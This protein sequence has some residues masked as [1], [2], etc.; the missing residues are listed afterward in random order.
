MAQAILIAVLELLAGLG[1][2]LT[3]MKLLTNNVESLAGDKIKGMFAKI[4]KS[5]FVG[6]GI[7]TATTAIVQSS[8]A[9]TVMVIGFV[10]AGIMSLTQATTIIYGA[11]IGTTITAQLVALGMLGTGSISMNAIFGAF[12]G[13]GAFILIFAQNDKL[14]RIGGLTA[15]FGMLFVGLSLMSSSMSALAQSPQLSMFLSTLSNPLLL[16]FAGVLVTAVLQSSS[17]MTG[18]VLTMVFG[19]LLTL[20]QGIYLTFGSNI[21]TC[22]TALIACIGSN[23]NAKRTA[24]IHMLFNVIGVVLFMLIGLFLKL[25]GL[26]FASLLETMFPNVVTT[27]LAMM[28]TIFNVVSVLIMLPFTNLLV[29]ITKKIMPE[30]QISDAEEKPRLNYINDIYLVTPP[31][32]I[33][34]IKNEVL[35]MSDVAMKN[36]NRSIDAIVKLDFTEKKKFE[37]DEELLNFMNREIIKFLVKLSKREN[38]TLD[39]EFI[40][41]IYHA[42]SDLER[43]GDYAENIFE[44]AE[45]LFKEQSFFSEDALQEIYELRTLI[46]NLYN[47]TMAIFKETDLKYLEEAREY[48]NKIDILAEK[49]GENHV[50]RLEEDLCT[51][52]TGALY[53][54]L[55]SNSERVADHILNIAEGVKSYAKKPKTSANPQ[56]SK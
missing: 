50:R 29:K 56:I 7:G 18:L 27:Q 34:Q 46:N 41:T 48:E 19:G 43:I 15:G 55:A 24:L 25:G 5:K 20:N 53:L 49:M 54:S 17:A 11:N 13:L 22:V 14:K 3:A 39:A 31:I 8:S 38:S 23:T 52:D 44:Y 30:K 10:N 33:A 2:F 37:K 51:P 35:Y 47:A 28:H 45:K 42:I 32:A 26:S 16:L 4:S 12:A 36:F 6:V 21:G 1:V 9:V 40:G